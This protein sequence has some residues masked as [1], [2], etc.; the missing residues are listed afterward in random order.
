MHTGKEDVREKGVIL[1]RLN[2]IKIGTNGSAMAR[3]GPIFGQ[4]EAH[5]PQ[6]AFS[7]GFGLIFCHIWTK[8]HKNTKVQKSL[9]TEIPNRLQYRPNRPSAALLS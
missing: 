6:E 5:S 4:E 3:H 8:S 7:M 9:K 2:F 1:G